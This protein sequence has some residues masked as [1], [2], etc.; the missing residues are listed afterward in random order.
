MKILTVLVGLGLA[1]SAQAAD[2]MRSNASMPDRI[3]TDAGAALQI[4][5]GAVGFTQ[6][7]TEDRVNTGGTWDIRGIYGTRSFVAGELAYVGTARTLDNSSIDGTLVSNGV[8]G[9]VR[10][11]API[12]GFDDDNDAL[13]E[14]Y[15]FGGVGWS[16][17]DVVS[18]DGLSNLAENDGV[19][20]IPLGVGVAGVYQGALL[21]LRL[22]YRPTFDSDISVNSEDSALS[23]VAFTASIG[24]EF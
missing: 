10:F 9:A 2:L 22:T 14:P 11:N 24:G 1:S 7:E 16:N 15:A 17:Y 3:V 13:I 20:Q 6:S 23:N 12:T 4:G 19:F 21:D 8:E 5:G 18:D